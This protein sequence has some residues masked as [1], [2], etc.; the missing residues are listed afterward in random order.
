[1]KQD[2]KTNIE[3]LKKWIDGNAGRRSG[4]T[5]ADRDDFHKESLDKHES[6]IRD[7]EVKWWGS[8]GGVFVVA[9]TWFKSL[10][11]A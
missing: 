2:R 1:M 9:V 5:R 8:L 10:F 4:R 7:L 6:K 11:N 3:R